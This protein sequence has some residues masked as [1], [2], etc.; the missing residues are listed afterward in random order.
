[1]EKQKEIIKAYEPSRILLEHLKKSEGFRNEIYI[2]PA[3]YYTIGYG[4]RLDLEG[5]IVTKNTKP[6]TLIE[7]ERLL[8]KTIKTIHTILLD[9][10]QGI[11]KNHQLEAFIELAF[12]IGYNAVI[13]SRLYNNAKKGINISLEDF[14]Q[15]CHYRQNGIIVESKA[16]KQRRIFDFNLYTGVFE[17]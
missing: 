7:G 15:F 2:C 13:K 12:N 16:L 3:G 4:S 1:M 17:K 8:S 5:N 10:S 9:N 6:I 11:F 14:T